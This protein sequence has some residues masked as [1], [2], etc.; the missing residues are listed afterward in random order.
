MSGSSDPNQNPPADPNAPQPKPGD[1]NRPD[2][3][4]VF[5]TLGADANQWAQ[6]AGS[7]PQG[8]QGQQPQGQPYDPNQQQWP[9][10]PQPGQQH[11]PNQQWGAPQGPPPG[12]PYDPNQQWPQQQPWGPPPGQPYPQQPG[13][14]WAPPPGQQWGP[15]PG[16]PYNPN[17]PYQ[18]PGK[19][20]G[21]LSKLVLGGIAAVALAIIA[22]VVIAVLMISG[23]D[24]LDQNAAQDGVKKVLSDSY[25]LSDVSD[26]KCPSGVTVE[27]NAT[28][29]CSVKIGGEDK[30]V[31]LKF[32]RDD[33][34]YEVGRPS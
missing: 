30:K 16:Q 7:Q 28:F 24:K 22:V 20:G 23:K 6:P 5:P 29:T 18:P 17:Q 14:P 9:V 27:T 19:Q 11:D 12:Q 25:G 2:A 8:P 32:V 15:P 34:T 10:P 21:G 4:R 3:T 33:G 26:V 31:T 13:Q 1:E